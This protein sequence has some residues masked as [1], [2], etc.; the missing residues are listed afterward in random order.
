MYTFY[1]LIRNTIANMFQS[2]MN[3]PEFQQRELTPNDGRGLT[4]K[5]ITDHCEPLKR[6]TFHVIGTSVS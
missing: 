1:S 6:E 4:V 2:R 3:T 5:E